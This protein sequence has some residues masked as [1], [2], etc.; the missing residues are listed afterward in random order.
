MQLD[1]YDDSHA[2]LLTDSSGSLELRTVA[3]P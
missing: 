2:V 1:K 3:L